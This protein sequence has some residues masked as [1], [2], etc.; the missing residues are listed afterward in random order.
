MRRRPGFTL[1]EIVVVMGALV[2]ILGVAAA[3]LL[4]AFKLERASAGVYRRLEAQHLLADQFRTDVAQAAAAPDS[5]NK[6]KAG[7]TCLILRMTD[8]S[9]VIYH[10]NDDHLERSVRRGAVESAAPMPVGSQ[11]VSAEFAR[12]GKDGRVITLRLIDSR[13]EKRVT[14]RIEISAAL[15]G[16]LR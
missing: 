8:G 13:A 7:P 4:G 14:P 5:L 10:W 16:D 1:I 3:L 11:R 6:H 15:G 12:S 2:L 9:H